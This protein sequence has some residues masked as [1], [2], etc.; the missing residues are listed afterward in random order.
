MAFEQPEAIRSPIREVSAA[1]VKSRLDCRWVKPE[2]MHLTVV[3]LGNVSVENLAAMEQPVQETCG[4]FGPFQ[5]ALKGVGCFPNARNPRV[6]WVGLEG[7][8]ERMGRFRDEVQAQVAPFGIK[9]EK[10][11][12]RP[13][14]TLGR[15]NR[16]PRGDR[17]LERILNEYGDLSTPACV[18]EELVLF[19]SEL[20]RGGSIYTKLKSWALTGSQ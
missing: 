7:D 13:H 2:S 9:E 11:P 14:L 4:R 3:F 5:I 15:F 12:F 6:L 19:K 16:S 18:L 17:E 1:L 8:I 20:R 10:R